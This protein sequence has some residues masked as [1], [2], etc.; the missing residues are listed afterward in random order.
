MNMKKALP[1]L[2]LPLF[3]A[4]CG[5][6]ESEF[7]RRPCFLIIENNLH[8][9]ATL[10]SAMQPQSGI[11]VRVT[12]TGVNPSYFAFN[13]NQGL[14]SKSIFNA[15]D[16]Q[17]SLILGMNNGLIVGQSYYG[18]FYAY[19]L[20]CPNCFDPDALPV[21]SHPLTFTTNG[22]A[23]CSNC[24]RTYDLN[25]GGIVASGDA[26]NKLTRYYA[27]TTGPYGVLSVN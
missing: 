23:S 11:F 25:N 7:S 3:L 22:Q 9:D 17:R 16:D 20:Q 26:G 10:A 19:D 12:L 6:T 24:H 8:N 5:H 13:S 4:A 14:S 21:R 2:L 15:K 27:A 1:L 18:Q